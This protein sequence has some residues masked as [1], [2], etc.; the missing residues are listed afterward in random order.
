MRFTY[1]ILKSLA[2][3][4][5]GRFNFDKLQDFSKTYSRNPNTMIWKKIVNVIFGL[6]FLS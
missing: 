3:D 6:I 5:I 4:E 2:M 1:A